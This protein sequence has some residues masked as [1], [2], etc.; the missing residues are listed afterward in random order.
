MSGILERAFEIRESTDPELF[1]LRRKAHE[2]QQ[3]IA[4]LT[5]EQLGTLE[6]F[7]NFL[8]GESIV[9]DFD[10]EQSEVFLLTTPKQEI[11]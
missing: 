3:D 7:D 1:E 5:H 2:T 8:K 4:G 10:R 11:R 6:N 9:S